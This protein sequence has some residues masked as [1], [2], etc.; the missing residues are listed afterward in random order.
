MTCPNEPGTSANRVIN[1]EG[2]YE[3]LIDG[4]VDNLNVNIKN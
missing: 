2:C 1:Q 3:D 4:S